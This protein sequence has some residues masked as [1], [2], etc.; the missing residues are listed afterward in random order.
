MT[1]FIGGSFTVNPRKLKSKKH[2]FD[3]KV[4]KIE[5]TGEMGFIRLEPKRPDKYG[6]GKAEM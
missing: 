5:D 6:D 4:N 3:S 2:R 1:L